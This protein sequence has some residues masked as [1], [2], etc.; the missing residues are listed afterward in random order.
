MTVIP[1]IQEAHRIVADPYGYPRSETGGERRFIGY[2]C[3]FVPEAMLHAAGFV[4]LRMLGQSTGLDTSDTYI[5]SQCCEVV[6]NILTAFDRGTFTFLEAAVFGFC[7]DTMQVTA[8]ILK[9]SGLTTVFQLNVPTKFGDVAARDYL[10]DEVDRFQKSFEEW[11]GFRISEAAL[12]ESCEI[13]DDGN[14]LMRRLKAWRK[15]FPDALPVSDMLAVLSVGYFIPK[16]THNLLLTTLLNEREAAADGSCRPD[17]DRKKRII[18]SGFINNDIDLIQRIESLDLTVV[19]DDLCEGSRSVASEKPQ[20]SA[21]TARIA[22]HILS[23]YCPVKSDTKESYSQRLMATYRE[24]EADGI[25]IFL[26]PFCDAQYMEYAMAKAE[27]AE[28]DIPTLVLEPVITG[29]TFKQIETR[30][31]AFVERL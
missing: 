17:G 8:N 4:P 18:V 29:D 6:K 25:V 28:A 10:I 16:E 27:L 2:N 26:Y 14:T 5:P 30:L 15:S 31:E 13:Y 7:C 9:E 3:L 12:V 22:D 11:L 24:N 20:A 19:D 1:S 23:R 21:P